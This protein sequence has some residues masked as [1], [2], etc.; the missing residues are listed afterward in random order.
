MIVKRRVINDEN[1]ETFL[2][3]LFLPKNLIKDLLA[4]NRITFNSE[5]ATLKTDVKKG[6]IVSFDLNGYEKNDIIPYK[7][8]INI[9]YEDEEIILVKKDR[10]I[11]IHNDGNSNETLLN[12][13]SYYLNKRGF[14]SKVR[15]L[16]RIDVDTTGLVLFSKNII[17]YHFLNRQMEEEKM[18]KVYLAI[19]E[20]N[21]SNNKGKI[22][23]SIGSDRHHNNRYV[24]S[25]SG[26]RALTFYEVLE[27]KNNK[28]LV[29]VEIKTGR[30][31]Q[32]RVHFSYIKHPL[33][34]DK[35]YGKGG[36]LMLHSYILGFIH[37]STYEYQEYKC[38][39]N[40]DF[41]L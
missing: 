27:R 39:I 2:K 22:D 17:S 20:G 19:L 8:E 24:V 18:K 16:H 35:I 30:T 5:V 6:D 26:K 37:P 13:V 32:I 36:N 33:V 14:S 9:V 25:K 21:L 1:I 3:E 31:H 15:C 11:L 12:A 28:T 38:E 34:G 7:K 40:K 4:S 23:Y 41:K 29:K 10:G